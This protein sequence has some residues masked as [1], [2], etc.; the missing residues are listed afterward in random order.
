MIFSAAEMAVSDIDSARLRL[1]VT[2]L[3]E[4]PCPRM[5]AAE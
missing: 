5:I 3:S 4:P 1:S 2:A